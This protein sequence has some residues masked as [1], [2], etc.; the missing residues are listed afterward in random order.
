MGYVFCVSVQDDIYVRHRVVIV[1]I[2]RRISG[3]SLYV[4][5]THIIKGGNC[6]ES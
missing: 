4:I 2:E 5:I 3:Q 6:C 1:D